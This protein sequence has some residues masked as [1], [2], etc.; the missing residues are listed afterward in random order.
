MKKWLKWLASAAACALVL[1]GAMAG[2]AA[3]AVPVDGDRFGAN[4]ADADIPDVALTCHPDGS[5]CP[6]PIPFPEP[7]T[8]FPDWRKGD[9]ATSKPPGCAPDDDKCRL[10]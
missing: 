9:L 5:W 2:D 1:S 7:P 4:G 8:P 3:A 6:T 10:A